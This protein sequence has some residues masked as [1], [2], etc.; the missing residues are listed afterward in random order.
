MCGAVADRGGA[1]PLTAQI[2]HN[3]MQFFGNF[4]QNRRLAPSPG[5]LAPLFRGILDPPLWWKDFFKNQIKKNLLGSLNRTAKS[6]TIL[7]HLMMSLIY[8]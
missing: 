2:F 6:A 3:F 1:P 5:G 8:C 7:E 4:W